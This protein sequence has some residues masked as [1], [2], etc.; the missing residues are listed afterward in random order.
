MDDSRAKRQGPYWARSL[1]TVWGTWG[2]ALI[3]LA[4]VTGVSLTAPRSLLDR[5]DLVGYALCH[6]IPSHSFHFAGRQLPLCARCSGIYLGALWGLFFMGVIRHRRSR[7]LPPVSIL[8]LLIGFF[9]L[10]AVDGLNSYLTLFPG[11]PHLY[12]PHNLLRFVTGA[13]N[14]L[15]ISGLVFPLFNSALWHTTDPSPSLR[16]WRDMGVLLIGVGGLIALV[17]TGAPVLLY[18]LALGSTLSVILVLTMV[19]TTIWTMVTGRE[20]EAE[21]TA[22]AWRPLLRGLC[23]SLLEMAA[24]I[25]MRGFITGWL[26]APL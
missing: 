6:R 2:L 18:P 26:D 4:V 3:L 8:T 13:L 22:Q 23:L 9:L 1:S 20:G 14:G 24:L 25:L 10:Q 11:L 16:G 5:C 15:T 12:E 21:S 7:R 17:S 19:N